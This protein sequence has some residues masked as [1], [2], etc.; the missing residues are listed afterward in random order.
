MSQVTMTQLSY[1]KVNI[2]IP[3]GIHPNSP[4]YTDGNR[5]SGAVE[6]TQ[7]NFCTN[8]YS[9]GFV[10]GTTFFS[11]MGAGA[12]AACRGISYYYVFCFAKFCCLPVDLATYV[13][14]MLFDYFFHSRHSSQFWQ[15]LVPIKLSPKGLQN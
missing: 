8:Y 11:F 4:Q 7:I 2:F 3:V 15:K 10:E 14:T 9:L 6:T 5:E 13:S 12:G 1:F